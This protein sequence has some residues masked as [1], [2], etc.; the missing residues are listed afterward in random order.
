MDRLDTYD[1]DEDCKNSRGG[2]IDDEDY[3]NSRGEKIDEIYQK[4]DEITKLVDGL[5]GKT[6]EEIKL[7]EKYGQCLDYLLSNEFTLYKFEEGILDSEEGPV[8]CRVSENN[9]FTVVAKLDKPDTLEDFY[10]GKQD[11]DIGYGPGKMKAE[12]F[13]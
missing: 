10:S 13:L 7:K 6:E 4:F 3:K 1:Y 5:P 12:E 9:D 11:A 2:K 8:L